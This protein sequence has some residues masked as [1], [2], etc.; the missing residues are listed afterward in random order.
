MKAVL[1]L[2]L[3]IASNRR[4]GATLRIGDLIRNVMKKIPRILFLLMAFPLV[5]HAADLPLFS[6]ARIVFGGDSIQDGSMCPH[7]IAAYLILRNPSLM[8]HCQ[9]E[10]RGGLSLEGWLD[11]SGLNNSHYSRLVS[12]Y[13]PDFF[14]I[15]SSSN[16]GF[17]KQRHKDAMTTLV[18]DYAMAQGAK[19]IM[20]GTT[21]ACSI[22]GAPILGEYDIANEEIA[23]AAIPALLYHKSWWALKDKWTECKTVTANAVTDTFT[24]LN[25]GFASG[26]P[27][28]FQLSVNPAGPA[29]ISSNMRY[30]LRDVTANTFKVS[31]STGGTAVDILSNGSGTSYVSNTWPFCRREDRQDDD[32]PGQAANIAF[33][34]KLIT[35]LG[36]STDVSQAAINGAAATLASQNH[37]TVTGISKNAYGG[38]DFMRLDDRLPWAI[39]E[40]GRKGAEFLYPA[41]RGWQTYTL[42]VTGLAIG[43]YDILCDGEKIGT[44]TQSALASGWNMADLTS[45]PVWRQCQEVLGRIRDMHDRSRTYPFATLHSGTARVGV[46]KYRGAVDN[47]YRILGLRGSELIANKDVQGSLHRYQKTIGSV[48]AS[49]NVITHSN[50]G[51]IDWQK[52][53]ISSTGALPAPL[54]AE[55][56]YYVR[57]R[58]AAGYKLAAS[59]GGGAIDLTSSG[60]GTISVYTL[61]SIDD[62]DALI[63]AAAQPATHAFSIRRRNVLHAPNGIKAEPIGP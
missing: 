62:L 13:E 56:D 34:W 57:D 24:A 3:L 39:D 29:G 60:S 49:T 30:Y 32:H 5:P 18:R 45:G 16:G 7:Y 11:P 52:L 9:T 55:T 41:M 15:S 17:T 1:F 58:T 28:I 23:V 50:Y 35:G 63:H 31:T 61:D 33:A 40:E 4:V 38:V 36:W 42:T 10:A 26:Q 25:H 53:R 59:I 44:A 48:D 12:S 43:N 14:F 46:E 19:V 47:A 8:L 51:Y 2:P 22:T 20:H 37:C 6:S 54:T 27:V 21:P